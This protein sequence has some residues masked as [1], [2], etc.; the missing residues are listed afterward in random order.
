MLGIGGVIG[1]PIG[2]LLLRRISPTAATRILQLVLLGV[3][4]T[5][6]WQLIA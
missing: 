2:A 4:I 6:A 1:A 3:S 5:L